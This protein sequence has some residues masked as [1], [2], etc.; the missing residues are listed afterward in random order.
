MAAR[1]SAP[2]SKRY[3]MGAARALYAKNIHPRVML[4]PDDVVQ[5]REQV[6]RGDG[7]KIMTAL[8]KK[9]RRLAGF[10]H[11]ADDVVVMMQGDGSHHSK[12]CQIGRCVTDI[13]LAAVIDEND[14]LL[15]AMRR[16][17]QAIADAPAAE[18]KGWA[19][20]GNLALPYDILHDRTNPK[21]RCKLVQGIQESAKAS[22]REPGPSRMTSTCSSLGWKPRWARAFTKTAIPR[23]TSAT[24]RA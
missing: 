8:R 14:Y 21:L 24:A 22:T 13:A 1:K 20:I 9:V 5:L 23:K 6:K 12:G 7:K 15:D 10:I 16:L 11:D 19:G 17:M 18:R 3:S 4:G 2:K